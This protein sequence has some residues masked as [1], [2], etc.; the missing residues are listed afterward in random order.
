MA[1]SVT[2]IYLFSMAVFKFH[3]KEIEFSV[4]CE[5]G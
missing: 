5:C 4:L 2:I 1:K 3:L